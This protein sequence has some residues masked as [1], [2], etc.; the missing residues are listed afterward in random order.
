MK[1]SQWGQI[2]PSFLERFGESSSAPMRAKP[3]GCVPAVSLLAGGSG[4]SAASHRHRHDHRLGIDGQAAHGLAQVHTVVLYDRHIAAFDLTTKYRFGRLHRCR[5]RRRPLDQREV[6]IKH[7]ADDLAE[8]G[9]SI[10]ERAGCPPLCY[11]DAL[12]A[13]HV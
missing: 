6:A 3:P 7:S 1:P 10:H 5:I 9:R 12:M 4:G 11:R 13:N 8:G 2:S